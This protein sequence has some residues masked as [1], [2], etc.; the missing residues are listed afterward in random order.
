VVDVVLSECFVV[1]CGV[2]WCGI[3]LQA[4][5]LDVGEEE[6]V[7]VQ[8]KK[9]KEKRAKLFALALTGRVLHS[10]LNSA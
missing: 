4:W 8:R 10:R 3:S 1:W 9:R 7:A 5:N 6:A 2:V